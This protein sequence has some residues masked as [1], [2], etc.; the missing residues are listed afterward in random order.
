MGEKILEH[1]YGSDCSELD[2]TS[3]NGTLVRS[4]G[5][6]FEVEPSDDDFGIGMIHCCPKLIGLNERI[7][8]G[9]LILHC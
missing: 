3:T 4:R 7:Y 5:G 2:Y 6:V 8:G 9:K 1:P